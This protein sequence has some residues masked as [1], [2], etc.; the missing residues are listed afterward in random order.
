MKKSFGWL[1]RFKIVDI[2]STKVKDKTL[3]S[4]N[5]GDRSVIKS[6]IL[7]IINIG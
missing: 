6:E 2:C 7:T 5:H 4:Y 3:S 1:Y